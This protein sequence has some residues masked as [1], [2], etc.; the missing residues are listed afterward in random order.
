MNPFCSYSE[1]LE[2]V[3]ADAVIASLEGLILLLTVNDEK[4]CLQL[5]LALKCAVK[6]CDSKREYCEKFV[7]LLGSRFGSIDSKQSLQ[8]IMHFT[9]IPLYFRQ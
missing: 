1:N 4:D 9:I 2:V 8:S 6:L 7:D 3:G 5:R